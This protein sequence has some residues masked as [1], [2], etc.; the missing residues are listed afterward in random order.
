M[1]GPQLPGPEGKQQHACC[2]AAASLLAA[3]FQQ[4]WEGCARVHSRTQQLTTL[5]SFA[6]GASRYIPDLHLRE[7]LHAWCCALTL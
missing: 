2:L 3:G 6:Y 1:V 4:A 5:R 7:R